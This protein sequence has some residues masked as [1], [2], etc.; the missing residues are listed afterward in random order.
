[1]ARTTKFSR[2]TF[3]FDSYIFLSSF[4][5]YLGRRKT[6]IV[7]SFVSMGLI[8]LGIW[9]ADFFVA[10]TILTKASLSIL[11][12][13]AWT[14]RK[15]TNKQ[16]KIKNRV[17]ILIDECFCKNKLSACQKWCKNVKMHQI[18]LFCFIITHENFFCYCSELFPT[19]VRNKK[20][21]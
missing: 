5:F 7:N 11:S 19:K 6:G 12:G 13:V 20:C 1:M 16:H 4:V 9:F 21:R 17:E 18:E 3:H 8:L 2:L 15:K 14:Y 10:S